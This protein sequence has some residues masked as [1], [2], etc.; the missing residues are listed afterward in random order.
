MFV[1]AY[2]TNGQEYLRIIQSYRQGKKIKHRHIESLGLF[3]K[4][5]YEK[6]R[7]IIKEW[8][9]LER[10][11]IVIE[12]LQAKSGRLQ[13]RGFFYAFRRW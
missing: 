11:E 12:E 1:R 5:K 13:G 8:K 4:A 9:A 6:V 2:K 7:K 10:A 3:N